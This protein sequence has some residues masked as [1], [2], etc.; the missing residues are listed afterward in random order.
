MHSVS[1]IKLLGLSLFV[2]GLSCQSEEQPGTF[3]EKLKKLGAKP[4]V[5]ISFADKKLTST[6]TAAVTLQPVKGEPVE[7]AGGAF[8]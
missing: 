2:F 5:V 4:T 3:A 6:G 8:F 7:I 1:R